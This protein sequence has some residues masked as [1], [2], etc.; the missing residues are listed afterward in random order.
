MRKLGVPKVEVLGMPKTL[1]EV[2]A[3]TPFEFQNWVCEKLMARPSERKVADMGVDGR[4]FDGSPLQV[5]QSEK[6]GRNVVDNFETAMR[7]MKKSRG[8]IV[9]FSFT[10]GAREEVAR[11]RNQEKLEIELKTVKEIIE[12]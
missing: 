11:A 3:L 8:V 1:E 2:S 10:A 7:R 12:E 4:L 5:K 9:A 6:V